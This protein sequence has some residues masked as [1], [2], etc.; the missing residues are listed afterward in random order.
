MK[1]LLPSI[2]SSKENILLIVLLIGSNDATIQSSK[3]HVPL[4]SYSKNMREIINYIADL[5]IRLIVAS[6]PPINESKWE[7]YCI[8]NFKS[9]LDRYLN[10][11]YAYHIECIRVCKS[12]KINCMNIW[13]L[14]KCSNVNTTDQKESKN[15]ALLFHDGLHFDILANDLF[16][17]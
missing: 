15:L 12:L 16:H 3:Q 14:F 9:G 4:E 1:E 2:V 17:A 8:E 10:D 11:V 5:G 7:A 13:D 6:P